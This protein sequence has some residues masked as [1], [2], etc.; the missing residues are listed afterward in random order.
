MHRAGNNTPN[1][2]HPAPTGPPSAP[3]G[4]APEPC[5]PPPG[6]APLRARPRRPGGSAQRRAPPRPQGSAPQ[7]P[8]PRPALRA[9][10]LQG[11]SLRR[12]FDRLSPSAPRVVPHRLL[13]PQRCSPR[14]SP[15]R[16]FLTA[17]SPPNPGGHPP[18][19]LSMW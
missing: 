19:H 9:A 16:V 11:R 3:L 4:A 2:P 18:I 17:Q 14:I 6:A 8:V 13:L 15:L 7:C 1:P 10:R 12:C 5:T